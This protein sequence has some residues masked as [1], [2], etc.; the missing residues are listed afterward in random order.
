VKTNI[1]SVFVSALLLS[2]PVVAQQQD[3][4]TVE[5]QTTE[6]ADGL[7][8]LVGSGGNIALSTGDDGAFIV[9]TQFAPL[10]EKIQAAVNA[11]GGGK[12][13]FVVNTH[14]HGDHSGGNVN[15]GGA[16]ATIMAHDNVQVRMS[17]DQVS[18]L[19]GSTIPASPRAAIPVVTYPSRM[20]FHWNGDT[21]NLI[22]VPNAHTDGDSLVHF[23]NL[24]VIHMGD[25][26]VNGGFPFV[27]VGSNGALDGIV[28]A[29]EAVLSRSD[30]NTKIIPGH[31]AL[32]TAAD[33]RA[34][35]QTLS[36]IRDRI[37]ALVDQGR[38]EDEVVAA[39]PTA[40]WDATMGAGFMSGERFTRLAYQGMTR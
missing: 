6:L 35:I 10:S 34:W 2:A 12:V 4:S 18:G 32:A 23:T 37:K 20:T 13:E 14:W 3:F 38:S 22:H 5:I 29:G 1:T 19:D 27:D 25:L 24:N 8:M 36:T 31:G 16:G 21:V 28:A 33:L 17:T 11:V 7:Y 30:A 26:Y 15:F 40:E 9:D 39:K